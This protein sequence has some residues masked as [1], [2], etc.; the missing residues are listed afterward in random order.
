MEACKLLARPLLSYG[1]GA[2]T[3]RKQDEWHLTLAEMEFV[4]KNDGYFFWSTKKMKK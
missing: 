4:R 1:N 2:W 3:I